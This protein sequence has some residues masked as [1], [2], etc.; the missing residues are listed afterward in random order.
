MKY[1]CTTVKK[2]LEYSVQQQGRNDDLHIQTGSTSYFGSDRN[3]QEV[4]PV[5]TS[6]SVYA[7]K[8]EQSQ[9]F[10]QEKGGKEWQCHTVFKVYT[11]STDTWVK[12]ALLRQKAYNTVRDRNELC[13]LYWKR[14]TDKLLLFV[15]SN[16]DS[17][18]SE[19]ETSCM[20]VQH[21]PQI[22]SQRMFGNR[23][24]LMGCQ[25]PNIH[26]HLWDQYQKIHSQKKA[27]LWQE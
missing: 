11:L 13:L 9:S 3:I 27:V 20:C 21:S 1:K 18:A 2:I 22:E 10:H 12:K 17:E 19:G 25:P 8:K 16:K 15:Q 14:M 6:R 26:T 23:W 24:P 4:S 7:F 5:K